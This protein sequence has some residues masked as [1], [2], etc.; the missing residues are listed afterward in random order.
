MAYQVAGDAA[1]SCVISRLEEGK[2]TTNETNRQT[3]QSSPLRD[4]SATNFGG[5]PRGFLGFVLFFSFF[6]LF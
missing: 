6:L 2:D 1:M 5:G 3:I 4:A